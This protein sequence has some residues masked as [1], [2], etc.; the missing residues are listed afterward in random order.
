[1]SSGRYKYPA[2]CAEIIH[3]KMQDHTQTKHYYNQL[4]LLASPTGTGIEYRVCTFKITQ[5]VNL[6]IHNQDQI[7]NSRPYS[8]PGPVRGWN[9]SANRFFLG[10][11]RLL[12]VMKLKSNFRSLRWFESKWSC[13]QCLPYRKSLHN[14]PQPRPPTHGSQSA[15]DRQGNVNERTENITKSTSAW[16]RPLS[17][18]PR[19]RLVMQNVMWSAEVIPVRLHH[20]T[21]S[22]TSINMN[23]MQSTN[24]HNCK[25]RACSCTFYRAVNWP[26]GTHTQHTNCDVT[27]WLYTQ[28]RPREYGLFIMNIGTKDDQSHPSNAYP[29][30][31]RTRAHT[32]THTHTLTWLV[33]PTSS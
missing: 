27:V 31:H 30:R 22:I 5:N 14:R 19:V 6:E 29:Y 2:A 7:S 9:N 8:S 28:K 26:S 21:D 13:G 4:L 3:S 15:D 32:Q 24:H 17:R 20:P 12:S 1:M 11:R 23:T 18:A 33:C 16:R 10:G 25:I